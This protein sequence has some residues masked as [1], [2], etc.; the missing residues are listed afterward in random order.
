MQTLRVARGTFVCRVPRP[1]SQDDCEKSGCHEG[2]HHCGCCAPAPRMASQVER[3]LAIVMTGGLVT[4]TAFTL[5]A[6]PAVYAVAERWFGSRPRPH[7]L[8]R[9]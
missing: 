6:L 1:R 9:N 4:S 2:V 3:P 7:P 5:I 8:P